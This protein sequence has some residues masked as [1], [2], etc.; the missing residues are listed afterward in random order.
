MVKS[1]FTIEYEI[2]FDEGQ[3]K[4]RLWPKWKESERTFDP[5]VYFLHSSCLDNRVAFT[6]FKCKNALLSP[7]SLLFC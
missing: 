3:K 4:L 5:F 2:F 1:R 7:V 6:Y